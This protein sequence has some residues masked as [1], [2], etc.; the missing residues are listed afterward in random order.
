MIDFDL[1]DAAEPEIAAKAPAS[2]PDVPVMD[3]ERTD[4]AGTLID[5][6]LDE[7]D[8]KQAIERHRGDGSG[9]DRR[10]RQPARF[11]L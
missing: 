4:V 1:G 5:F 8:G 11:Q 2:K 10:R 7:T 6:N 3:L 9:A